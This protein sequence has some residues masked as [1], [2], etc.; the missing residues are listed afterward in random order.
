MALVVGVVE[1]GL[2]HRQHPIG[3]GAA[4]ANFLV[5]GWL[6]PVLRLVAF[7]AALRRGGGHGRQ[8]AAQLL[9]GEFTDH[10]VAE[11]GENV[12]VAAADQI[13]DRL[14]LVPL[15]V[16][17]AGHRLPHRELHDLAVAAASLRARDHRARL[18]FGLRKAE[19]VS[20]ISGGGIIGASQGLHP[21]FVVAD[22]AAQQPAPHRVALPALPAEMH[23]AFDERLPVRLASALEP[24]RAL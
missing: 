15:V 1:R 6:G 20:A 17:V 8:P 18:G 2:Q 16:D 7:G 22:I 5:G 10:E 13:T 14:A 12:H 24:A 9:G 21:I 23:S 19:H 4:L 11:C 3:T